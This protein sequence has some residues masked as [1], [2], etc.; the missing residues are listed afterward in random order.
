MPTSL[1]K[2]LAGAIVVLVS[3]GFAAAALAYFTGSGS[4]TGTATVAKAASSVAISGTTS[5]EL[6]PG[7]SAATVA[8]T[9][10]NTGSQS[11]YVNEVTL[12][13]I[14]PD[15][16][17]SSCETSITGASPAFAMP[18]VAVKRDL[19]PG[20]EAKVSGAL[21]MNDTGVSQNACQEAQ[22]TLHFTS[23]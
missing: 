17:H 21:T 1:S 11:T 20:E 8:I 4:G 3:L 12:T 2:R 6:Y 18:A 13:S 19:A 7:G 16:A 9:L 14:A 5:G 23:D 15:A 10:K 22:L